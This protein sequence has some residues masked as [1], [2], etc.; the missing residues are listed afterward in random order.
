MLVPH[1]VFDELSAIERAFYTH[2]NNKYPPSIFVDQCTHRW[3]SIFHFHS[4]TS[5]MKSSNQDLTGPLLAVFLGVMY[6]LLM[7]PYFMG[8]FHPPQADICSTTDSGY[9]TANRSAQGIVHYLGRTVV[10]ESGEGKT[11]RRTYLTGC[12]KRCPPLYDHLKSIAGKEITAGFCGK[13]LVAIA[14]SDGVNY[15]HGSPTTQAELDRKY[16]SESLFMVIVFV[17]LLGM[18]AVSFH[19][20][21]RAS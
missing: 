10:I 5:M 19:V 2:L 20:I 15:Y 18:V 7:S 9:T 4:C 11:F 1:N 12:E 13:T 21:R 6:I 17:V 16:R 3:P 14:T 8:V